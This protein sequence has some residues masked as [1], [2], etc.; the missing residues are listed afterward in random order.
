LKTGWAT[1]PGRSARKPT[2]VATA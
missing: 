1:G 2:R